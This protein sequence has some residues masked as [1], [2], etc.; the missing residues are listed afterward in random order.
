MCEQFIPHCIVVGDWPQAWREAWQSAFAD[1]DLFGSPKPASGWR[2]ASIEKTRKGFGVF[3]SWCQQS[4]IDTDGPMTVL[5]TEPRAKAYIETL[6]GCSA[7][8]SVYCR[9]QELYDAL[10]IMAPQ[11]SY[12]WLM[13]AVRRLRAQA[14]PVRDKLGRLRPAAELADYGAALM[15]EAESDASLAMFKRA[16]AYRDGLIIELLIHRPFR[17]KNFASITLGKELLLDDGG[18]QLVFTAEQTKG[19]RSEEAA[20]PAA[21]IGPLR[22]YLSVYRPY[23]LG[24]A[25]DQD[26]AQGE[27]ALWISR[28]GSRLAEVSLRNTVK[29]RTKARFG[30]DLTPHL[31]RD[32]SVTSLVRDAPESALLTRGILMQSSIDITNR[33]YNQACMIHSSRRHSDLLGELIEAAMTTDPEED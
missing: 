15:D 24:L 9:V 18:A 27:N 7:S 12:P 3:L 16:L 11:Q 29:R 1:D 8:Y 25:S 4:G 2:P 33:H 10:R 21:L 13:A 30:R 31:F 17:L 20:F 23:L 22:R 32:A 19:K 14:Q 28:E 26:K 5:V 6:Q